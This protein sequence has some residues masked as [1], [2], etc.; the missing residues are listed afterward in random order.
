M[1]HILRLIGKSVQQDKISYD[2]FKSDPSKSLLR[3]ENVDGLE[4]AMNRMEELASSDPTCDYFLYSAQ[5]GKV[6]RRI[7]RRSPEAADTSEDASRNKT[8]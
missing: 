4:Q 5:A 8:G 3:I 2:I 1:A 7:N 6:I